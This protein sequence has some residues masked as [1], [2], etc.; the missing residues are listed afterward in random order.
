MTEQRTGQRATADG[1]AAEDAIQTLYDA[2][3]LPTFTWKARDD[4]ELELID[5]NA[6]AVQASQGNAP[7]FIGELASDL[8]AD[9][10]DIV[11]DLSTAVDS[12]SSF[13]R[14]MSYSH[15]SVGG[16]FNLRV[17]YVFVRPDMVVVHLQNLPGPPPG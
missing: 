2:F 10:P 11:G 8:Y 15:P 9:R 17:T 5:F 14:D 4:G 12:R 13:S 6:A 7:A 16:P 3:P 1:L